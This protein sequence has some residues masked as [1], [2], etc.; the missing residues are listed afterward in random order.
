MDFIKNVFAR[1]ESKKPV[2]LQSSL[3]I[4]GTQDIGQ[5]FETDEQK[6][7]A[8]LEDRMNVFEKMFR[9]EPVIRTAHDVSVDPIV[10]SKFHFEPSDTSE[11]ARE[12]AN[13]C[14]N[15]LINPNTQYSMKEN[16]S[17]YLRQFLEYKAFGFACFEVIWDVIDG[18]IIPNHFA[19]R[20]QKTIRWDIE[21]DELKAIKQ[22]NYWSST[23]TKEIKPI[24]NVPEKLLYFVN[25]QRGNDYEGIGILRNQFRSWKMKQRMVNALMVGYNRY[26]VSV[27]ECKLPPEASEEDMQTAEKI[28]KDWKSHEQSVLIYPEGFDFKVKE[29]NM[30]ASVHALNFIKYLDFEMA[31]AGFAQWTLL[32]NN[33]TGSY[34]L[35]TDQ[36]DLMLMKL[37][38]IIDYVCDKISLVFK[39]AVE[40][41]FGEQNIKYA[42]TLVGRIMDKD[43]NSWYKDIQRFAQTGILP[44]YKGL[45]DKIAETLE[46]PD[47]PDSIK[48][49]KE[50]ADAEE[51]KKANDKE[52]EEVKEEEM[53]KDFMKKMQM[54]KENMEKIE[55]KFEVNTENLNKFGGIKH[56]AEEKKII[57][58]KEDELRKILT[59]IVRK[60]QILIFEQLENGKKINE[61]KIDG[62]YKYTEA[63]KKYIFDIA[64][65]ATQ[66]ILKEN[67]IPEDN[68]AKK[69]YKDLETW[70]GQQAEA[71]TIKYEGDIKFKLGMLFAN[72]D[73]RK[74][75]P[76]EMNIIDSIS[77]KAYDELLEI[78]RKIG[79]SIE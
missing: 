62:L 70:A 13:F 4:S 25:N 76:S 12:I 60:H 54:Y 72:S 34:S 41:N 53:N 40:Y 6:D 39:K 64:K 78:F 43:V 56:F 1:K 68:K 52:T 74:T 59:P 49:D 45:Q 14:Q 71:M 31:L 44:I 11:R 47:I 23:I 55:K 32:G 46:L 26:L 73:L 18:Y 15:I 16:F 35:S 36:S 19:P 67:K 65:K 7:L 50:N 77:F 28:G 69:I 48:S 27:V 57:E 38:G 8:Y 10:S 24:P 33:G 75:E 29:T 2:N 42:P 61:I 51:E 22:V 5:M 20:L 21:D 79:V 58:I 3:G 37:Q 66:T 17:F 63:L 30:M 9:S